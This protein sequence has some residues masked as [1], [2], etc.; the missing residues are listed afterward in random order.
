MKQ[1]GQADENQSSDLTNNHLNCAASRTENDVMSK[2][3]NHVQCVLD[4]LP[5][6]LTPD[7]RLSATNF[8]RANAAVFSKSQ[9]DLGRTELLSNK[10]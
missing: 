1:R 3:N 5:E 7:Q 8:I 4:E 6:C 10:I 2:E 9:F